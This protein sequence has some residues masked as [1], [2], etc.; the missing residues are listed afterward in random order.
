M[1]AR[2]FDKVGL[3]LLL[4]LLT[5]TMALICNTH[6]LLFKH[7]SCIVKRNVYDTTRAIAWLRFAQNDYSDD[8][9]DDKTNETYDQRLNR[10]LQERIAA[11]LERTKEN[12][13]TNE[14]VS[15]QS[16]SFSFQL[17][18]F[19]ILALGVSA[20]FVATV[21]LSNGAIFATPPSTTP[22]VVLDADDI[23]KQDFARD[24]S[25]VRFGMQK[26]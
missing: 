21:T 10:L 17:G 7:S 14:S 15:S 20:F 13:D 9:D 25:S 8:D 3:A 2:R 23:L 11:E 24:S 12:E 1:W 22:R 6:I 19:D 4:L 18:T 26:E 5:E 16:S